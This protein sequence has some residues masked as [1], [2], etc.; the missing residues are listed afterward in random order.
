MKISVITSVFNNEDQIKR[1][2]DSIRGQDYE[3]IET[4][5]IDG[6][7]TDQTLSIL[8][9]H[10]NQIDHLVSEPDQGVYD[11]LNK[12]IQ[13]ASGDVIG[14][15]HSDDYFAHSKVISKIASLLSTS[16]MDGVYSDLN[17]M[18]DE[19]VFRHWK[20]RPFQPSLIRSGWMPPHP[21]LYLKKSVYEQIGGFDLQYKIAADY[22]FILRVFQNPNLKFAY[23]PEVTVAMSVGGMSNRSL[24][25]IIQKSTEDY[26]I[27]SRH[28]LSPLSTLVKKNLSKI[29]QFLTTEQEAQS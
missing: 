23:L 6:G 24:K 13:L 9:N 26:Q 25:N 29:R 8:K 2:L 27:L 12:G 5:V 28:Q 18:K 21:T 4:I 17:Y 3:S 11:A 22:D 7:S 16:Q 10:Q 20:S 1:T 14:F 15:L 19:K